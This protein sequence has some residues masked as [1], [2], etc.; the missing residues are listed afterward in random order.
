MKLQVTIRK[1]ETQDK[2]ERNMAT[3]AELCEVHF[4]YRQEIIYFLE[5]RDK[6]ICFLEKRDKI[7]CFLEKRDKIFCFLEMT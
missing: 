5:K 4:S 3:Q 7:I 1:A 2:D 6:I